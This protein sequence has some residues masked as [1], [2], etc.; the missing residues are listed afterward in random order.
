MSIPILDRAA[1]LSAR[2]GVLRHMQA[3]HATWLDAARMTARRIARQKGNVTADDV[4]E[5]LY[6]AGLY[7]KHYNAWG[8]VFNHADFVFTGD[9]RRSAVP[10]GKGN[11]QRV[12]RLA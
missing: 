9:F 11:M 5:I 12:W 8:A 10:R 7:P 2:D 6:P 3:R 1:A 4:R